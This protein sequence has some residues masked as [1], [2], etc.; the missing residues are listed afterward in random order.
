MR[1]AI[2][3]A[4]AAGLACANRLQHN[5]IVPVVF[6]KSRGLGG[7]MATRRIEL[8]G[9]G[10]LSFDHGAQFVRH[11]GFGLACAV[12]AL[13]SQG[14]VSTWEPR[15]VTGVKQDV[16]A[17]DGR[18]LLV[19]TPAMNK[20]FAPLAEDLE[21]RLNTQIDAVSFDNGWSVANEKF[22]GLVSAIPAPQV[23]KLFA[24]QFGVEQA[25]RSVEIAPCWALM[26]A[27]DQSQ[28]SF[29]TSQFDT[30]RH[31]SDAIGWMARDCTKPLRSEDSSSDTGLETWV[32]HASPE[33]SRQNLELDKQ[34]AADALF[35]RWCEV[36]PIS[37]RQPVVRMAHRWRYAQTATPMGRPYFAVKDT[38]LFVGGDWALGGRVEAAFDSGIAMADAIINLHQKLD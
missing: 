14:A 20:F 25:L 22:D 6:E 7:R 15:S 10:S 18:P 24:G 1:V 3:G 27:F 38:R 36:M 8:A 37:Y 13:Q 28:G 17:P 29:E 9:H 31:V 26:L 5:G 16:V 33:W 32:V 35:A 12:E 11:R 30:W 19:G 4:G 34:Q 2:L 23:R 21:V